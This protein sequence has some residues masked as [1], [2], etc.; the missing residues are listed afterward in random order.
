MGAAQETEMSSRIDQLADD[1][2]NQEVYLRNWSKRTVRTYR[3][4]LNAF[5]ATLPS[6]ADE[7]KKADLDRFVVSLRSR[8]LSP[9]VATC[10]STFLAIV[11]K[12]FRRLRLLR[13]ASV[14][15]A[16]VGGSCKLFQV[17]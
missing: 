6:P 4:G 7:L 15:F 16:D 1:F 17:R 2:L 12:Q 3:Q 11:P 8:G 5:A 14:Q 9:V 13:T 10:I